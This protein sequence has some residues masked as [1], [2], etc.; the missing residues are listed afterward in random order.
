[1][2]VLR[3]PA[4]VMVWKFVMTTSSLGI[5]ISARKNVNTRSLPR[6]SSREKAK[7]AST[8]TT[9]IT[10]VVTSVKITVLRKYLP[11]GTAVKASA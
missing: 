9:S 4:F 6:N 2:K 5:I 3:S 7:A 8:V 1:M 10:P 11:S